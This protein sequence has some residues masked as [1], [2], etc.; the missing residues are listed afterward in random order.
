MTTAQPAFPNTL[1]VPD[2]MESLFML[3]KDKLDQQCPKMDWITDDLK[4][5]LKSAFPGDNDVS[6]EGTRDAN[7]LKAKFDRIFYPGRNFATYYQ[8][9]QAIDYVSKDWG[10]VTS[11]TNGTI[12]CSFGKYK[13][14]NEERS[15]RVPEEKRRKAES[16]LTEK[17]DCTFL[18]MYGVCCRKDQDGIK[19]SIR[20]VTVQKRTSCLHTC[21][22]TP[23]SHRLA[24]GKSGKLVPDLS[25]CK[26]IVTVLQDDPTVLNST[27]CVLVEKCMPHYHNPSAKWLNNLR[28]RVI[29]FAC[30]EH[31]LT[32]ADVAHWTTT[33]A[34]NERTYLDNEMFHLNL[35]KMLRKIMQS[36]SARWKVVDFL[37]EECVKKIRG[38]DYR[39]CRDPSNQNKPIAVVF[40]T[41]EMRRSLVCCGM[42]SVWMHKNIKM[43]NLNWVY[44]GPVVKDPEYQVA[45]VAEALCI[46]ESIEMYEFVLQSMADM[47][48]WWSL[49]KMQIL[50][51]DQL[52]TKSI[53]TDLD[54]QETCILHGNL[55]HLS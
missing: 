12:K 26:H 22:L 6:A 25:E 37:M 28:Q 21:D 31:A 39:I 9:H 35:H 14:K 20:M 42:L 47:E 55:Y 40:M 23:S 44:I 46:E 49:E 13:N 32:E 45:V 27:L 8:L 43:N 38:F 3:D 34:A 41:Q 5:E 53:L 15:A 19:R 50:F 51:A 24:L 11:H 4:E 2:F 52:I 33:G 7:A 54:I 29:L 18:V 30:E 17:V 36:D 16:S 48:K 10:F 1:H